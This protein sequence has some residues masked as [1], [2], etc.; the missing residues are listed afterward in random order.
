MYCTSISGGPISG[1]KTLFGLARGISR[2]RFYVYN[3]QTF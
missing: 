3:E 2:N 1:T